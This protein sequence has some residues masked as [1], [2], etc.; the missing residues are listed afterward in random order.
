[1]YSYH[2]NENSRHENTHLGLGTGGE[3]ALHWGLY[4]SCLQRKKTCIH[5]K[6]SVL[7]VQI[8][9]AKSLFQRM[10]PGLEPSSSS[11]FLIQIVLHPNIYF[12]F[13]LKKFKQ[14]FFTGW[15]ASFWF[16]PEEEKAFQQHTKTDILQLQ[17]EVLLYV[18][19][20]LL[21]FSN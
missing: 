16:V 5:I 4:V 20:L 11:R 18:P 2:T 12:N 13:F 21:F 14:F 8:A 6:S 1:M 19:S 15:I 9:G 17:N 7:S 3:T 10:K